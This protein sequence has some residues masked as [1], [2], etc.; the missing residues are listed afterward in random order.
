M[1][2]FGAAE[3]LHH[4]FEDP[5]AF[6]SLSRSRLAVFRRVQDELRVYLADLGNV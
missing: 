1:G 5:A 3:R 4:S 2:V 6:L